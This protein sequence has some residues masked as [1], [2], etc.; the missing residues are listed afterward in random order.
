MLSQSGW[1]G[2][3]SGR[4][5]VGLVQPRTSTRLWTNF[6]SGAEPPVSAAPM[7]LPESLS[8]GCLY[9]NFPTVVK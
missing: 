2:L 3:P 8:L 4:R 1:D 5:Q 7:Q 9:R 6:I